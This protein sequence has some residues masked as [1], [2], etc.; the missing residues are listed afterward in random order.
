VA[1]AGGRSRLRQGVVVVQVLPLG[2]V[3]RTGVLGRGK[4]EASPREGR[5]P[6]DGKYF[7]R[8][9]STQEHIK[10]DMQLIE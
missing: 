8:T 9:A 6:V 5:K 1:D 2:L 7:R 4:M 10:S 3:V